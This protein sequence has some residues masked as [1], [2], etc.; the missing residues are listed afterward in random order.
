MQAITALRLK[1]IV[2][3]ILA[4]RTP[5]VS[6]QRFFRYQDLGNL[7][8]EG[9]NWEDL[10]DDCLARALDKLAS[11]N[12]K[13]VVSSVILQ[14]LGIE[15][16]DITH[17]H[18]DTTS[19]SVYGRYENEEDDG[20]IQLVYGHSKD[21][22]PDLKQLK[23][24]LGVNQ[25]GLPVIGEALSGNK[26]DK[27]WNN[28]FIS[29]LLS[30][31]NKI[32]LETI[33]YVADSSLITKT[34]LK[35][36]EDKLFFISRFPSTFALEKDLIEL[37][38]KKDKWEHIGRV[39]DQKHAAE[40]KIQCFVRTI[41]NNPYKFVVVHSSKLDR[42]K[43]KSVEKR[44]DSLGKRL[45]KAVKA[46]NKREF[47]CEADAVKACS[48]FEK[49]HQNPFYSLD[50][51]V[52]KITRPKKKGPGRPSKD[53]KPQMETVY[54]VKCGIGS[55]NEAAKQK[56][57]EQASCFVLITN[58]L[59]KPG[60]EI[61]REYKR[62]SA[63]ETSFRF[64]KSPVFLDAIYLKKPKRIEALTYVMIIALLLYKIIE[65]RAREALEAEKSFVTAPGRIKIQK[66]TGNRILELLS[67][68]QVAVINE[69]GKKYRVIPDI[70]NEESLDRILGLLG[71]TR[72]VYVVTRKSLLRLLE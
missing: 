63:V 4:G 21:R 66:P 59:D 47:A 23:V 57:L 65:K 48:I 56:A 70:P 71:L 1:A 62:Q 35:K 49:Q 7:F 55:I 67:P 17:I 16:A 8:G 32:E 51:E 2:I 14:A 12:P 31:F 46:L 3:N 61:L 34:N 43:T 45:K 40:Y 42:R 10:N 9:V 24:G 15:G 39:S 52:V 29:T 41:D 13:K 54:K 20:F 33:I 18:G 28:E 37:S 68:F 26:D 11:A 72:D 60:E 44:I 53:Y 5:L 22:R 36:L 58:K 19:I 38:W 30:H 69:G 64:L 6:V 50:F 27:T 25:D